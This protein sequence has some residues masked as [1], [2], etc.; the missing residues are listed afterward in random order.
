M[1]VGLPV[2][3]NIVIKMKINFRF[4]IALFAILAITVW[5]SG[6]VFADSRSATVRVS[7]TILPMIQISTLTAQNQFSG[8]TAAPSAV[9]SPVTHRDELGL[10]SDGSLISIKTNLGSNYHMVQS[11]QKTAE[12]NIKLYSVTAL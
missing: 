6:I 11:F 7:C 1:V 5:G 8:L 9:E 10:A 4:I 3:L 12:G 2:L